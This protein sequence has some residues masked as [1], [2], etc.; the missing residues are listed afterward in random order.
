MTNF[1]VNRLDKKIRQN[2]EIY[3]NIVSRIYNDTFNPSYA[4]YI[5]SNPFSNFL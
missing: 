1:A 5:E 4:K 2:T 3:T